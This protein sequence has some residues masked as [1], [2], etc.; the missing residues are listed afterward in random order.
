[1]RQD[2]IYYAVLL[3]C[4]VVVCGAFIGMLVAMIATG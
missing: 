3:A 2:S 1:M 4:C